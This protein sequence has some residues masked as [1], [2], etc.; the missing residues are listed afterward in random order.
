MSTHKKSDHV[1]RK[2]KYQRQFARTA[3]NK[4]R[5]KKR[6]DAQKGKATT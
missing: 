4:A 2:A 5:S 1:A 6:H 3:A